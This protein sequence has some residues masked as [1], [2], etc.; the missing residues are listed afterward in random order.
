MEG[1][2][3]A[4]PT[5]DFTSIADC[6]LCVGFFIASLISCRIALF[7]DP[8]NRKMAFSA[9]LEP[10]RG[11]SMEPPVH[12]PFTRHAEFSRSSPI[13]PNQA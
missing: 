1:G 8:R 11:E 12:E 5:R 7:Y 10:F 2:T 4:G 6:G 9:R 13:K 3:A